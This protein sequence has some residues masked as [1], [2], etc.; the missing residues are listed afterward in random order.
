[1]QRRQEQEKKGNFKLFKYI[2]FLDLDKQLN[3]LQKTQA[4]AKL[5]EDLAEKHLRERRE[6]ELRAQE[7]SRKQQ[8]EAE[9]ARLLVAKQ[10][11]NEALIRNKAQ[12]IQGNEAQLR[13]AQYLAQKQTQD[14]KIVETQAKTII[15]NEAEAKHKAEKL[16]KKLADERHDA[17]KHLQEI[18]GDEA[19]S[20]KR[21][22]D[23]QKN[24]THFSVKQ[25]PT[26][27]D[28]YEHKQYQTS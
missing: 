25:E 23:M 20:K 7:L 8:E 27:V 6:L 3:E 18:V 24:T 1:M 28:V 22:H 21:L 2:S 9:R 11:Q 19:E 5:T 17:E 16:A 4:A 12:N 10:A 15:E 26:T 13:D 14:K